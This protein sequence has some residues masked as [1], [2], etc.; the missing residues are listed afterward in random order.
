MQVLLQMVPQQNTG[1]YFNGLWLRSL[2]RGRASLK[3]WRED[4]N[5]NK[6]SPCSSPGSSRSGFLI[7]LLYISSAEWCQVYSAAA[8]AFPFKS[9]SF[10][11]EAQYRSQVHSNISSSAA[12]SRGIPFHFIFIEA[13]PAQDPTAIRN[14][15][16]CWDGLCD[17]VLK[18]MSIALTKIEMAEA[19]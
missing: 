6:L 15:K 16:R 18:S 17:W 2:K 1:M 4:A 5:S 3:L 14:C 7:L 19:G 9:M 13:L 10:F 8:P 11:T 12:Y